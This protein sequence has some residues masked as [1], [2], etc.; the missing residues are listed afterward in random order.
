MTSGK[1]RAPRSPRPAARPVPTGWRV[2]VLRCRDGT[3]YCGITNDL[4]RR[5]HQHNRGTGARYTRGRG[6]V[7]LERSWRAADKSAA[8]KAEWA[9]KALTR[10]AKE[11][12]LKGRGG[13]RKRGAARRP[14]A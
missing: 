9:F 2:Y 6:P 1:P 8:L 11:A 13:P 3:L 4:E 12:R 14:A 5:L 10:A 7:V